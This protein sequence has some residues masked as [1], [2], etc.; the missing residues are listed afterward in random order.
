MKIILKCFLLQIILLFSNI[1]YSQVG[2]GTTTPDTSSALDISS[3]SQGFL[4]PR[5]T[6]TQRDLIASPAEGL[7]IYNTTSNDGEL[8]IG[9]SLVPIWKGIKEKIE[10]M[11]DSVFFGD[12][13]STTSTSD[14]LVPGLTRSL[15]IGTYA[16][17]FNGQHM[18]SAINQAF[19]TTEG[20]IDVDLIYQ[21]LLSITATDSIHS[22]V[23]GNGENLPPGVYEVTG[24]ASV[25]GTLKLDGG[26]DPNSIFIIRSS[27]P[28]TTGVGTSVILT[29]G[30][31]ANN[32][33]WVSEKPMSTGANSIFKGSLVSR[34]GAISLGVTTSMEGRMFTKSGAL[35]VGASCIL[36]IPSGVSPV[37]L[38]RLSSFVMFTTSGTVSSDGSSTITGDVGTGMGT[39]AIGGEHF[40]EQYPEGTTSSS[41]TTATYCIYQNGTPVVNSSRRITSLNSVVSLKAHVTALTAGEVVEV[42]WKVDNG[43]VTLDNRT[44]LLIHSEY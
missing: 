15:Q 19:N 31:S 43:E 39:I 9:T 24:S 14:V 6:T 20:I 13:I 17:S 25:A 34:S 1:I 27:G 18:T 32:I 36:A 21:D 4:M 40:G 22:L 30:A 2:I 5:L 29:N 35:S 11:I 41:E 16:V 12:D 38:R 37:D 28:L 23:F 33:F 3:S 26:G 10:P 8:N 44:L 7:M 42:R